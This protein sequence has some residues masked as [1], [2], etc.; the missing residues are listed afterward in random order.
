M[1]AGCGE[2]LVSRRYCL[3]GHP[4]DLEMQTSKCY[5]LMFR[6]NE[7]HMKYDNMR[8]IILNQF[9]VLRHPAFKQFPEFHRFENTIQFMKQ[10][11][12]RHHHRITEAQTPSKVEELKR[13]RKGM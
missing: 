13:F 11:T 12:A 3:Q 5:F 7:T 6:T 9:I 2:T 10:K 4:P 8:Q 1:H